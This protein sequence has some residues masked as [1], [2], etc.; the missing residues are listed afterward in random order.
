MSCCE[1]STSRIDLY[2]DDELRGDE[3]DAFER[4]IKDCSSCRK[5]LTER[6]R[7]LEQVRAAR[8]LYAPSAK[9]RA[10]MAALLTPSTKPSSALQRC[11][12]ATAIVTK[13]DAPLWL[14][15]LRSK[16]I[17]ALI[18]CA[19][20]VVGMVTLW[21][22]SLRDAR[23]N[24]FVDMAVETHHQ[25]LA[26]QFP[27]EIKANSPA[28]VS[29]WFADKVPFHFRLPTSQET[30]GQDRRYE[31]TGGRLVTFKGTYAAY[32]AYRMHGQLIS[33]VVTSA[34]TSVALGGEE[35][36]SK[37]LTFHTHRK[38]ELQVVTWSVHNLTYALV[39]GVNAPAGQSCAVCHASVKDG[40]LIRNLRS[41]NRRRTNTSTSTLL[42][43]IDRSHLTDFDEVGHLRSATATSLH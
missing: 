9:F 23:A 32:I 22:F 19:L 34:S 24:A 1:E 2:L 39:S 40:D 17:P 43:D 14:L 18:A 13:S 21:R 10:E 42:S 20:T 35:S 5:E 26:G 7:F 30:T 33:L 11:R 8:P 16:S 37:G 27:L 3:L 25:Q 6:R 12:E 36:I 4:H 28:E 38:G 41:L 15:W 29:T 31:L